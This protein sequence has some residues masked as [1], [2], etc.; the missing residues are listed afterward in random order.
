MPAMTM[1]Y[2][3]KDKAVR[4]GAGNLNTAISGNSAS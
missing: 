2:A 4:G 1:K 3:V